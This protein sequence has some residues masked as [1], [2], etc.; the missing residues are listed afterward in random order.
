MYLKE[1]VAARGLAQV[2]VAAAFALACEKFEQVPETKQH[3][4]K[5]YH[6]TFTSDLRSLLFFPV[7]AETPRKCCG[8][9]YGPAVPCNAWAKTAHFIAFM[10]CGALVASRV[11]GFKEGRCVEPDTERFPSEKSCCTRLTQGSTSGVGKTVARNPKTT[12]HASNTLPSSPSW[13]SSPVVE[14]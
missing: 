3:T 11:A 13:P 9:P 14:T 10:A 6:E 4:I 1:T 8:R 7:H 5:I 2:A 12:S